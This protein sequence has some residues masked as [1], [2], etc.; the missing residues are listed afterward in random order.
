MDNKID[1]V[2]NNMSET[3][4]GWILAAR[5]KTI[6]SMLEEIRIKCMHMHIEMR[7]FCENKWISDISPMALKCLTRNTCASMR[8]RI[9][10]NGDAG[11]EVV[12]GEYRHVVDLRK[13]TCTCRAWGL[14]GIPCAHVVAA[15]HKQNLDPINFVSHWYRKEKYGLTY[16][17]FIQPVLNMK[18]WPSSTNPPIHPP[19]IRKM[20]GRPKKNR[21]KDRDEIKKIG[22]LSRRG[23]T[24]TCTNCKNQGHNRKGC[25]AL[26]KAGREVL[27]RVEQRMSELGVVEQKIPE[28]VVV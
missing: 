17:H 9:E 19:E 22:K 3:F 20:P 8:C 1:V 21:R 26:K 4:N 13:E 6:I 5:H 14:K 28:L 27:A 15:L 10:W 2:D 7:A 16:G 11:F 23:A 25:P 24:M 18:M 12:E